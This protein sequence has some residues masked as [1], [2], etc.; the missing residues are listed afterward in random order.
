MNREAQVRRTDLN[1]R[2]E[3]IDIPTIIYQIANDEYLL[4][5][6]VDQ[7]L[8][9]EINQFFEKSIRPMSLHIRLS[10][11]KPA[12]Y[13]KI[14]QPIPDSEIPKNFEGMS[15]STADLYNVLLSKFPEINIFKLHNQNFTLEVH[16]YNSL[17]KTD[18]GTSRKYTSNVDKERI[19]SFLHGLGLGI[20]YEIIE[21]EVDTIPSLDLNLKHNPIQYIN[22][23]KLLMDK[24]PDFIQRD[25]SIWYDNIEG[26]FTG[27][28]GKKDLYFLKEDDYSCYIDYT[29]GKNIDIRNFLL[30]Y[31]T[32]YITPPYQTDLRVWIKE[33]HLE[34]DDFLYLIE[35]GRIKIILTQYEQRYGDLG[36]F[37]EIYKVNRNGIVSRRG[38]SALQQIDINEIADNYFFSKVKDFK[39]LQQIAELAAENTAVEPRLIYEVL[40]WP[41]KAKRQSF[42]ALQWK[43]NFGM[44]NIGVNKFTSQIVNKRLD[45]DLD[46]EFMVASGTIHLAHALNATYFPYKNSHGASDDF[47]V[48]LMGYFLNNFKKTTVENIGNMNLDQTYVPPLNPI[49][50]WEINEYIHIDEFEDILSEAGGFQK[51]KMLMEQLAFLSPEARSSKIAEYNAEIKKL[52]RKKSQ[53]KK[54]AIDLGV[55]LGLEGLGAVSDFAGFGT[56]TSVLKFSGKQLSKLDEVKKINEKVK[57]AIYNTPDKKNIH[58]L[59]KINRVARLK[60]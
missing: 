25:E 4:W 31:Q 37:N 36:I 3:F 7:N 32:V 20:E 35:K 47:Y 50:I 43:G 13:K 14:I 45:R 17:E 24:V 2:T 12:I 57:D 18:M 52:T 26:M 9:E 27:R 40:I 41:M 58:F 28:F 55:D 21:V 19:L 38:V 5:I 51:G 10:K 22:A 53:I 42:E 1:F 16:I 8:F 48:H 46:L 60:K 33:Q 6:D 59:T 29:G 34:V 54:E 56:V 44:M 15:F 23:P 30:L 49:D 11:D 39:L